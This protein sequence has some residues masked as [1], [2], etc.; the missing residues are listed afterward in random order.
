MFLATVWAARR[1]CF[2]VA[3]RMVFSIDSAPQAFDV[4]TFHVF[5]PVKFVALGKPVNVWMYFEADICKS[6]M[7]WTGRCW[8]D[9][10]HCF[11]GI[12]KTPRV[13][14][15]KGG[16]KR[17]PDLFVR[18]IFW[19]LVD[20]SDSSCSVISSIS[21]HLDS[22]NDEW[23]TKLVL[24][25]YFL[26]QEPRQSNGGLAE[27]QKVQFC[28]LLTCI[29]RLENNYQDTGSKSMKFWFCAFRRFPSESLISLPLWDGV[30]DNGCL[31]RVTSKCHFRNIKHHGSLWN[32]VFQRYLWGNWEGHHA[33]AKSTLRQ[34]QHGRWFSHKVL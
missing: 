31:A 26:C 21:L 19:Q 7:P 16:S 14:N 29:L 23:L 2:A 25:Q 10:L 9:Y 6:G 30:W 5:K 18:E 20:Y 22:F 33:E 28:N 13:L 17:R 24:I 34:A 11:F 1:L 32:L 3:L 4:G 12:T 8:G 15:E 27:L